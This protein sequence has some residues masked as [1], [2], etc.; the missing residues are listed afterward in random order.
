MKTKFIPIDYDYFDFN[1]K[2]Y[3]KIVGRTEKGEKVCIIDSYEPNFYVILKKG[4]EKQAEKIAKK[5]Q[6][7]KVKKA[8]RETKVTKTQIKDKNFLEKKY[9]TIQV[10]AEN[11]KDLHDIADQIDY[12]EVHKRREY[13][14]NIITK[15]II[16]KQV[17]P[18]QWHEVQGE[19][20]NNSQELGNIDA[21]IDL[22]AVIKAETIKKTQKQE[23][24]PNILAYDIETNEFEIGKGEILMISLYGNNT[25]K[26]ITCKCKEQAEKQ[27]NIEYYKDEADMI[28]AFIN[29]VKKI[30]PDILVGYFS[31]NFDLPYLRARAEENNMKLN[32]GIDNSQPKFSRGRLVSGKIFGITHL[33]LYRFISI[34]YSQY[35]NSETLSLNDVAHEL[36]GEEKHDFDFKLMDNMT[37]SHW[38]DFFNYNLQDSKLT[39]QLCEKLVPDMLELS[40]II[41]EPLFNITRDSMS[42]H[43]ENYI[44]HNLDKY[45]EVAEK[46]PLHN[47]IGKRRSMGKY[48]G[49]FVFEPTPGLYENPVFFDFTSMYTSIAVSYNLSKS[50]NLEKKQ[51]NSIEVELKNEKAY[52]TKKPGFFPEMLKEIFEKRKQFKAEYKKNPDPILKIRSNAFKL[53]A[54]AA[55][56]YQGF[57]GARYYCREAAA[58]IAALAKKHIL[59]AIDEIKK[60]KYKVIYSDSVGEDTKVIINKNGD[61][62]ETKIKN[63]FKKTNLKYNKK[64]YYN[65]ANLKILTLDKNGKSVFKKIKYII[66]HKTSKQMYRIH[67]TNNWNIDITEDHSLIAYQSSKFN[68]KNK[69]KNN[70]L[71]RL[72]E[73]KP[74]EIKKIANSIISLKKIPINKTQSKQLSKEAYEFLG[75][76]I[77]D[78]SFKRNNAHKRHNKDYYL[79]L[80]L[81]DDKKEIIKR[82]I[83]PLIKQKYISNFWES[84]SRK[85]DIII[86]GLNFIKFIAEH[87]RNKDNKKI[88][89]EWLLNEKI[90]N[91]NSFL[92]G[93]FS[94]DGTVII[95]NNVPLIRYSS[96]NDRYI[97]L[98]RKLLYRTSISHSCFKEQRQNIYKTKNKTYN[99]NS[100]SKHI[101]IKDIQGFAKRIGFLIKRKNLRSKIKSKS[102]KRKLIK[103][104]EFDIQAVKKIE[105]IHYNNY[106]YDVEIPNNHR[107][108]ANYVLAHNTDSIA[109][110]QGKSTQSQV[111][112]FLKSLNK[113]LPGIMELELEDF[114]KKGLFVSKR[115]TKTGAKKKYALIDEKDK[116]KIRGFETVRR[117]WCKLA[118]ELQNKV[119]F[120]ILKSGNEEKAL[121]LI[122]QTIQNVKQR[123]IKLDKLLIKTQLKKPISEYLSE[124]PHVTAAKKMKKQNIP[125]DVGMLIEYYIADNNTT[126]KQLVRERV[127]LPTEKGEYD[128]EYYLN[129]QV[130]PAVE[131]I[132]DVFDINVQDLIKGHTQMKLF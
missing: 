2:N 6:K 55:Y 120:N 79:S 81:G 42:Q 39:Y 19:L 90:E 30:N 82:L 72:I 117:D 16:E 57:F 29:E 108:F 93:L 3:I 27:K 1:E 94:A 102:I 34:T 40:K 23:F 35:M 112:T 63:L 61:I 50:T 98:T 37:N 46:R 14:I 91:L 25:K 43:V 110:L 78:G 74:S 21:S 45:N 24:R 48:G 59:Q 121:E 128:I 92:R 7:I 32:L 53:I 125:V 76:F 80:S 73:I 89:P 130:L 56:G 99:N 49:A 20:L 85:G 119:L 86:S 106:V 15:Y 69:V 100:I 132:L 12:P 47:E 22:K 101:L 118:R 115:T 131:N 111:K 62:Y 8:N 71:K 88:I 64:E 5:I 97:E 58:S 109:F 10:Y 36:L 4:K 96:I 84:K 17:L 123:K 66:R 41:Q 114:Y 31:D 103:D 70:P 26:V 87:C 127:N 65:P 67:F 116:L 9:K 54:N 33:D 113:N 105:K 52:F 77:G 60:Q 124:G 95:R 107:F 75:Y 44:L 11:H 122:K 68:Q 51:E 13:D 104:F 28:E 126:K 129:K 83:Q 38:K 18:L